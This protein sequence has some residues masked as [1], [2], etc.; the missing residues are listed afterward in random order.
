MFVDGKCVILLYIANSE[1]RHV[2]KREGLA[3]LGDWKRGAGLMLT[4]ALFDV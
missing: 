1:L 4:F 3:R 2:R